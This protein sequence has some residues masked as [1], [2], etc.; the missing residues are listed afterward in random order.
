MATT[1]DFS[2][3]DKGLNF[4][5][6]LL[7]YGLKTAPDKA[8]ASL[9]SIML[10][11]T[12]KKSLAEGDFDF[13]DGKTL[14]IIVDDAA[15]TLAIQKQKSRFLILPIAQGAAESSINSHENSTTDVIIKGS[16]TSFLLMISGTTDPDTLF[17][18][19]RITITGNTDLSLA[20]KNMLGAVEP[21]KSLPKPLLFFISKYAKALCKSMDTKPP[22]NDLGSQA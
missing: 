14:A 10:N 8:V 9:L 12:L 1:T 7:A 11:H 21:E 20:V 5:T 13:F 15:M 19:R 2:L 18:R 22:R 4:S 3:M 16:V 6:K 17:F